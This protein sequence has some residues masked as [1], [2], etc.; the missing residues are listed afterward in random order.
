M[1]AREVAVG[2]ALGVSKILGTFLVHIRGLGLY[3][4]GERH[5]QSHAVGR[6]RGRHAWSHT[7]CERWHEGSHSEK[8]VHPV[9][10]NPFVDI[11]DMEP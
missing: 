6:R 3:A 8:S 7:L 2:E 5:A 11:N 4:I 9:F 10:Q 1:G